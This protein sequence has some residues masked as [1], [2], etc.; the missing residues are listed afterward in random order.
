M[1]QG[2]VVSRLRLIDEDGNA[3]GIEEVLPLIID[4]QRIRED[5]DNINQSLLRLIQLIERGF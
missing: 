4:S 1:A 3:V 5:L 2:T